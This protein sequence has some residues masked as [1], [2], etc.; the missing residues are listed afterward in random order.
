MWA[1]SEDQ[2]D[3]KITH[4]SQQVDDDLAIAQWSCEFGVND[5]VEREIV[6]FNNTGG[7]DDNGI[8]GESTAS[9]GSHGNGKGPD[10]LSFELVTIPDVTSETMG[11]IMRELQER[12]E[13]FQET[14]AFNCFDG[15]VKSDTA[16]SLELRQILKGAVHPLEKSPKNPG[17]H[18]PGS[19]C[20]VNLVDP[21]LFP[22]VWGHT[23]FLPHTLLGLDDCL[24]AM[25]KGI[26]LLP[27]DEDG[28]V[29][30]NAARTN[31]LD[32]FAGMNLDESEPE[33]DFDERFQH[34]PCEVSF[35]GRECR[36]VSYI[37]NVHPV[38]HRNVYE[39]IEKILVRTI[40]LWNGNLLPPGPQAHRIK[41]PDLPVT[42]PHGSGCFPFR[43]FTDSDHWRWVQSG[44]E[45]LPGP[46]EFR[47]LYSLRTCY[48]LR[49]AFC[50]QGLQ[51]IVKLETVELTPEE[52]EL[53]QETW[54]LEGQCVRFS[55]LSF[56]CLVLIASERA[57]LRH[58]SLLLRDGE[59]RGAELQFPSTREL[60]RQ[61]PS[62]P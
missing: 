4:K 15:V 59:H 42:E 2:V 20:T 12:A 31:R 61:V 21:S 58:C 28:E 48:D 25:G 32:D 5:K 24:A 57:H 22:L 16:V 29:E 9:N 49:T 30:M 19:T 6:P 41:L 14:K 1:R 62:R 55:V 43:R 3:C 38:K 13:I 44:G 54:H 10:K 56:V 40:P 35:F 60:S 27:A 7:I 37:N 8:I 47:G 52:P 36:I 18:E 33:G 45:I 53:E 46:G 11:W 50:E 39:V 34:L 17:N 23:T 26:V 51:V